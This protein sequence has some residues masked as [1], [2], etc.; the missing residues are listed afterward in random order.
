MRHDNIHNTH[1][2][3]HKSHTHT[4]HTHTPYIYIYISIPIPS[5][6]PHL[7]LAQHTGPQGV[8]DPPP[9]RLLLLL[10]IRGRLGLEV[11][12]AD[13]PGETHVAVPCH[14][15]KEVHLWFCVLFCFVLFGVG[16]KEGEMK[17]FRNVFGRVW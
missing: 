6:A 5:S 3:T 17:V 7:R 13:V 12:E 4:F 10:I 15:K 16:G 14:M 2:D 8:N 11:W 9:G 1:D